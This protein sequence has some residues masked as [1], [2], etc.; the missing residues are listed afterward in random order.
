MFDMR[1]VGLFFIIC[2]F[3]FGSVA[4][5]FFFIEE[6][7]GVNVLSYLSDD[8][9]SKLTV[10]ITVFTLIQSVLLTLIAVGI[11]H[12]KD[13]KDMVV[14]NSPNAQSSVQDELNQL[15]IRELERQMEAMRRQQEHARYMPSR[16]ER[17]N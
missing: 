4:A 2:F 3:I 16:I 11:L 17:E 13:T 14:V 8:S 15:R 5:G 6:V 10:L 9:Y 7:T 12:R 1:A